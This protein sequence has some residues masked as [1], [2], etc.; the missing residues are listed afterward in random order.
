MSEQELVEAQLPLESVGARLARAREAAGQSRA[1]IAAITRIPDRHLA[2]IERGDFAALPGRTYAV[3]FA[4]TYAK[5]LGLDDVAIGAE[6]REELDQHA[7]E[8]PR[9]GIPTFEPGDPARVPSSRLAWI[10]AF[11]VL[12][13]ILAG[14]LVWR[15]LFAPG[16]SLP[17]IL[18]SETPTPPAAAGP[19]AAPTAPSGPVVFTALE[20]GVWVKF[21]DAAGGQLLQ[22]EL[23]LGESWTVPADLPQV[24]IW[25][26]RPEALAI[27][28]GGQSVPK[29]SEVQKTIKDVPVTAAALLARGTPAAD[30]QTAAVPA[31][32]SPPSPRRTSSP[33][34]AER[35]QRPAV[36][37]SPAAEAAPSQVPSAA[38]ASQ[39][40]PT[41]A[42]SAT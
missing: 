24:T 23:A 8:L 9:R 22:R 33:R 10:S 6:V 26:A 40:A 3:G 21:S 14:F 25:T 15:S 2:A 41:P 11:A 7:P 29:L 12:A 42:P 27:T 13:A 30:A 31:E 19:V 37:P 34:P 5:A 18:P 17:S 39:S 28:I 1:Q 32:A 4:R 35:R 38:P 16:G 36:Q 20:A